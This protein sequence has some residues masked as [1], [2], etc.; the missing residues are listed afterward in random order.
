MWA[1]GVTVVLCG[2]GSRTRVLRKS[3]RRWSGAGCLGGTVP[4]VWRGGDYA[5]AAKFAARR[6]ESM[7]G[8]GLGMPFEVGLEDRQSE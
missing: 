3:V 5:E 4:L 1:Q 8:K 2:S 6:G 7:P